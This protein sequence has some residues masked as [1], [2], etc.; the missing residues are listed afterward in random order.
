[1]KI[2]FILND[3]F[4]LNPNMWKAGFNLKNHLQT[5]FKVKN[6]E[7]ENPS[8]FEIDFILEEDVEDN[9]EMYVFP[10]DVFLYHISMGEPEAWQ[11][12]LFENYDS[13][14]YIKNPIVK[15]LIRENKCS[16]LILLPDDELVDVNVVFPS[17]HRICDECSFPSKQMIFSYVDHK[18]EDYYD[19]W[20]ED[21]DIKDRIS[22][23]S[24]NSVMDYA[25][26][27][28]KDNNVHAD[29][30]K[31]GS[32]DYIMSLMR[33][34]DFEK[35]FC[36]LKK[37]KFFAML[38]NPRP[39]RLVLMNYLLENDMIESNLISYA[40]GPV[41][42]NRKE[43]LFQVYPE[44]QPDIEQILPDNQRDTLIKNAKTLSSSQFYL[45]DEYKNFTKYN[46]ETIDD[47]IK[48]DF[49]DMGGISFY[50]MMKSHYLESFISIVP[51]VEFNFS[52]QSHEKLQVIK[53]SEKVYKPLYNF[54][55]FILQSTF[56]CLKYLRKLGFKTFHPFI[57]ETYDTIY[58]PKERMGYILNE[59]GRLNNM[60]HQ[61]LV[62]LTEQLKSVLIHNHFKC[63]EY[64]KYIGR[65][66]M[67][68]KIKD[69][70]M[71]I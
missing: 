34:D 15:K 65:L 30:N 66:N 60:T 12:F 16:I 19:S 5:T 48:K 43:S 41:V 26:Q 40:F 46:S 42:R 64:Q 24:D 63:K 69:N 53:F 39:S 54:H 44:I 58:D 35:H 71:K 33:I 25:L 1:M 14:L 8:E 20:C 47:F 68:N 55:P 37:Y 2:N 3:S 21:N 49:S 57:D 61:Q 4:K 29:A 62:E 11:S 18:V 52:A 31:M 22:V 6:W 27:Y 45:H 67:F 36:D 70:Y 38:G 32:G 13:P 56:H 51:E 50:G 17:L 28:W 59:I 23:L 9:N 10:I 7:N